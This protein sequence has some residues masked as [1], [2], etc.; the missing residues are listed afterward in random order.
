[1]TEYEKSEG[2]EKELGAYGAV[3]FDPYCGEPVGWGFRLLRHMG[4]ERFNKLQDFGELE[5][6][7]PDWYLVV[8]KISREQAIELYGE[9]TAEEFGPRGGWRSITF[10][11]KKFGSTYLKPQKK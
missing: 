3:M 10:G 8:K 4:E 2:F 6:L 11:S 5:C 9:I 7:Y 1:M